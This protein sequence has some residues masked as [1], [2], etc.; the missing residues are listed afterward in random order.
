VDVIL[1]KNNVLRISDGKW[2][3]DN[4]LKL[5]TDIRSTYTGTGSNTTFFLAQQVDPDEVEVYVDDVL[6]TINTDYTIRKESRKLVFNTAPVSNTAIKVVY[7]DFDVTLLNNRKITGQTS[8]ATAIIESASKRIITDRLNFGLPFE[9]IIDK[10]TLN[11]LFTNGEQVTTDIIDSN[12]TK[13]TLVADTFSILTS[14]LVTGSGASYNIGDTVTILGGGATSVA[15]AEVESVTLGVTN[16]IVVEYGGSG[17]HTASIIT[18]QEE[19]TTAIIGAVDGV[20]T[21]GA[22]TNISFLLTDDIINTYANITLSA[23]DYGFPSQVIPAGENINTRI[24]DALTTLTITDLGPM[25]N[26]VVLFSN[27]SI[28]VSSLDSEGAR[29]LLG[30]TI[31]DI[32]SFRAIGR[33]DVNNGGVNYKVGD[34]II[35]GS[36]P[37]G[38]FGYGAA[39]AVTEVAGSGTITK[40]KVQSQRVAGTANVLNNSTIIVGTGTSFGTAGE[41]GVGD[42]ITIRSQERFINAVTS[43]TSATV[44][45][46][47]SFSDGTVWSNNAPIGSLSRGVVGGINYTQGTFPNVTVS[48]SNGSGAN[49]AIT[50][51]IGDGERLNALTDTVPGQI[52]SIKVTSGGAGYQYIPQVDLT[53]FGDGSATATAQ[54]GNSYSTLS[55]RWTTSDSILSS[56]E[57]KLQGSDYYVDYSYITS[58]LTEFTRY[59]D[60]LRQL[61]HPSGFV[62]YS[63][64]NKNLTI[65]QKD[66]SVSRT[67]INQISGT[68]SVS[69]GKIYVD[70]VN[71]KFNIANSLGTITIGTNIA[72]NGELRIVTSILSNTN[73]SVSS[74]WTMNASGEPLN[75]VT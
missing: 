45:A 29:Y 38:T 5:E 57:R 67:I 19:Q 64:L 9:L 48:S 72:V 23:A 74:A 56:S 54:V 69:N 20:D 41:P 55:G 13:I 2:T 42:K 75:I 68:V 30:S 65:T 66:T 21:S 14:I 15:T 71:T 43:S 32:K 34:E 31:Y 12:G 4:I 47:F 58:S 62:N 25:T 37:P 39:A 61:L 51:L 16:R 6:K 63:D 10:K 7:D 53:N 17:F 49:I 59:K 1:P 36:N 8:G 40:I 26:A 18:R 24:F 73:I 60:V 44:N 33:I 27:T 46:A 50:A 22:N 3:V 70:G 35:F 52:L 11:G 28:N